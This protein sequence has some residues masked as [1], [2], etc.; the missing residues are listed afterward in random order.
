MSENQ[1]E[2]RIMSTPRNVDIAVTGKCNLSCAYCFYADEMTSRSDLSTR[3]WLDFFAV[4]GEAGVMT[5]CLTGG[6][7][8]SRPDF[9]ELVDGVIANHMRY[10]ILS[11]GTLITEK[12][13]AE[14]EVG[15]RRQRLDSIQISIDGSSAEVH[16]QSRPNSFSRAIRGLKLLKAANFPLTVRVTINRFNYQDLENTARLLLEEV[17]LSG[18]STNEAYPC[19]ATNRYEEEIMLSVPQRREV[20]DTLT[21]LNVKYS[22]RISATAGP[23]ALAREECAIHEAQTKGVTEF[24]GRGKLTACGGVFEKLAI[25]HDGAIV[26]CHVISDLRLGNILTDNLIEIWQKHPLMKAMR[27]RREISLD[28]IEPCKDCGYKGY[29]TAGCPG[30]ALFLNGDFN[31]RNPMDCYRILIGEENYTPNMEEKSND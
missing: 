19:G 26:P 27:E 10:N 5:V 4:L 8:L 11:N 18:F 12:M 6:E 24:P 21:K 30:G 20:M 22:D 17:G 13:L 16:D 15:K 3:Q 14:F 25:L 7:A 9:F 23:L 28:E 29:C 1:T 31:Q 2:M